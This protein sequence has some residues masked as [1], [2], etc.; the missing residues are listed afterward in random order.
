MGPIDDC[1]Q[2]LV[3]YCPGRD[4]QVYEVLSKGPDRREGTDDDV[5]P[6]GGRRR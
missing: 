1:D 5:R 2:P 4:G 3:F 6:G